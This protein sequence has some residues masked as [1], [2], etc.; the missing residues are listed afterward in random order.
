MV[1]AVHTLQ[2]GN[3]SG[4]NASELQNAYDVL[5][6]AI[7]GNETNHTVNYMKGTNLMVFCTNTRSL[8]LRDPTNTSA[9]QTNMF[10]QHLQYCVNTEQ[11]N[12]VDFKKQ[13]KEFL[14]Y[15]KIYKKRYQKDKRQ[16]KELVRYEKAVC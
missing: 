12:C 11:Q 6:S 14:I 1:Y 13:K 8:I 2:V 3:N 15:S 4:H 9:I 16:G 5:L 7:I 10:E